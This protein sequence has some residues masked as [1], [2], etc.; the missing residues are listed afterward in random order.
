M[1]K[2]C[3]N[4]GNGGMGMLKSITLENYKC[5]KDRTTIDIAPLTVLCGVNSSGKSSILKSLLMM[6]QT[7]ES[8]LKDFAISLSGDLVD[9]GEF[10]EV[11]YNGKDR[12]NNTFIISNKFKIK[13]HRLN[14]T[15]EFVKRSD[16]AVFNELRRIYSF[17]QGDISEFDFEI[18]IILKKNL[19]ENEFLDY[20][21]NNKIEKYTIFISA[22]DIN[23][24]KIALCDGY[25]EI[26]ND[27]D[28]EHHFLNWENIPGYARAFTS[29]T[30]YKCICSFS[31]LSITNVFAYNMPNGIKSVV[32]NILAI[33]R[34]IASQYNNILY[35]AP[36][37]NTPERTYLLNKNVNSVGIAGQYTPHL[38]AKIKDTPTISDMFC[39][40][41]NS[42]EIDEHGYCK[43]NYLT[44]IR[45]WF[46]YF[47]LGNLDISGKNRTANLK[48]N[49]CNIADVGF[50]ISQILPIITQGVYMD[51]GQT[52]L[53]EQP[54][55]HLHPKME[56][57]MADFLLHI[58]DTDRN[59]V[60]ETHSEHIINRIVRR[61]LED[62]TRKLQNKVKIYFIEQNKIGN[63]TTSKINT[64]SISDE[65]GIQDYPKN[66]FDQSADEQIKIMR[67]GLSKRNKIRD[68]L[69]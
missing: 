46:K 25:I 44:F 15:G 41:T 21:S 23:N 57:Q 69:I 51:K 52:L 50:G 2:L 54:E 27:E 12:A 7:V 28:G 63:N 39:P 58:A 10:D 20:F 35:I 64:V 68:G 16:A 18:E 38:L 17:I 31:G 4:G 24:N 60:V 14:T 59:V 48:I 66:F 43:S 37:R 49:N 45:Q 3:Y 13:N 8:Q 34:I 42:L 33:S 26:V 6:K 67:S 9:C 22:T 1:E 11:I 29:Y 65:Y 40:Y 56:L 32:P 19:N 47:E 61:I 53:I 55:I 30:N 36:L 62:D 5:F